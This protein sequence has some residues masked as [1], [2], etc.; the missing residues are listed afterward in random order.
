MVDQED[1]YEVEDRPTYT[2]TEAGDQEDDE[3]DGGGGGGGGG[4]GSG[5]GGGGGET[6]R[7]CDGVTV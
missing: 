2:D 6:V 3:L 4:G 7:R 1:K 5:G